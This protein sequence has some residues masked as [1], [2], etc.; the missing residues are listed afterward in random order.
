[1]GV[2][3]MDGLVAKLLAYGLE[4]ATPTILIERATCPDERRIAGAIADM[5]ALTR[6]AQ[7]DGPCLLMIG[8]VFATDKAAVD[9]VVQHDLARE[10]AH[11]EA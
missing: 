2:R 9:A 4:P 7:P 10:D 8:H 5:P 3:T 1:M 11:A 6:A